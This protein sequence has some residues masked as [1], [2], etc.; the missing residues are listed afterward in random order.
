MSKERERGRERKERESE[1]EKEREGG[2]KKR[3]FY[4][5]VFSVKDKHEKCEKG[6]RKM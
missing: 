4:Y 1:R 3:E 5:D 6:E 2:R